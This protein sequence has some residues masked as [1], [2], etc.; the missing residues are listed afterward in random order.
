MRHLLQ[1]LDRTFA[2]A[3]IDD[4]N[5]DKRALTIAMR[6][7]GQMVLRA[8]E[9]GATADE[10]SAIISA[11]ALLAVLTDRDA[12]FDDDNDVLRAYASVKKHWRSLMDEVDAE[13]AKLGPKR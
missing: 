3:V 5:A 10:R 7:H 9:A 11:L 8:V 12:R 4:A 6:D 1:A 2:E 13:L